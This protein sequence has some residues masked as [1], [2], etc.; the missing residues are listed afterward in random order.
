M[1]HNSN[2]NPGSELHRSDRPD[3]ASERHAFCFRAGFDS[4]YLNFA[5]KIR[6]YELEDM[7]I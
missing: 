2:R 3:G 6:G 1:I 7:E 4:L 5:Y